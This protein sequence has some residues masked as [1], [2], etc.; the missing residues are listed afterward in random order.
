[1]TERSR[2]LHQRS[3]TSHVIRCSRAHEGIV[4][5]SDTLHD[6]IWIEVPSLLL[7]LL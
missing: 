7:L 6:V 2:T 1:M 4:I 5:I 3:H